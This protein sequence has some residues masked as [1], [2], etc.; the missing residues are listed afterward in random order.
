MNLLHRAQSTDPN[1]ENNSLFTVLLKK[2]LHQPQVFNCFTTN[3]VNITKHTTAHVAHYTLIISCL[4]LR[5]TG[6]M[7]TWHCALNRLKMYYE[8]LAKNCSTVCYFSH[9][10]KI[11]L[12]GISFQSR[13]QSNLYHL[14]EGLTRAF[15]VMVSKIICFKHTRLIF[16]RK[17]R[18]V[19]KIFRQLERLFKKLV[20]PL[21]VFVW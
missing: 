17:D 3:L 16:W 11:F 15:S 1:A 7:D 2:W 21:A 18:D 9:T 13:H 19:F 8:K 14:L 20:S 10:I 6:C 4:R 5:D 12:G